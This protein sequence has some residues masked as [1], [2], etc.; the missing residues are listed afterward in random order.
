MPHGVASCE[1]SWPTTLDKPLNGPL[2][3]R[4]TKVENKTPV[5]T[6]V[7]D[8]MDRDD[9]AAAARNKARIIVYKSRVDVPDD[10]L[11]QVVARRW[12]C[13]GRLSPC[14]G[15]INRRLISQRTARHRQLISHTSREPFSTFARVN[16]EIRGALPF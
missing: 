9:D 5:E 16:G 11:V 10:E 14:R 7:V 8:T 12:C 13:D 6:R 4:V 3:S 2:I 15:R 1:P